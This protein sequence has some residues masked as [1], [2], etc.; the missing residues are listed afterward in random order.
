MSA[1]T[2]VVLFLALLVLYVIAKTA[3]V[4]PQQSAYSRGTSRQVFRY[5]EWVFIFSCHSW[6]Q[7]GIDIRLKKPPSTSR[8][9]SA[10]HVITSRWQSTASSISRCSIPSVP[11]WDQRLSFRTLAARATTLRSEIG[12]IE[13]DRTF[14]ERTNINIQV[15]NELDKASESG[16]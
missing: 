16:A 9:K 2:F 13:L 15:V 5:V 7:S 6:I 14:E 12:K 8:S 11:L 4:V 10:S 3:V 1:G